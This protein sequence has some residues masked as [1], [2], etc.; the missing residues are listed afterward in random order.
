[1][2]VLY[3]RNADARSRTISGQRVIARQSD[4]YELNETAEVLWRAMRNEVTMQELVA[5]LAAEFDVQPAVAEVD[6]QELLDTL[7][8]AGFVVRSRP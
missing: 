2:N 6:V 4:V 8:S 7:V 3:K 1:M 5:A